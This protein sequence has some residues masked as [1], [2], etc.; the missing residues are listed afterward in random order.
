MNTYLDLIK[1]CNLDVVLEKDPTSKFLRGYVKQLLNDNAVPVCNTWQEWQSW[2]SSKPYKPTQTIEQTIEMSRL[3]PSRRWLNLCEYERV[4]FSKEYTIEVVGLV[5][6]IVGDTFDF[7]EM[8]ED[9]W[10]EVYSILA[11]MLECESVEE[12]EKT[13]VDRI[14]EQVIDVLKDYIED[15]L[16]Q[17]GWD[18]NAGDL[19]VTSSEII[20]ADFDFS[21]LIS[22]VN[23]FVKVLYEE[24]LNQL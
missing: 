3:D 16:Y 20:D 14:S 8:V 2:L 15:V 9:N 1:G 21:D 24:K 17:F 13:N 22:L 10:N 11:P 23:D 19:E 6:R 18:Y 5:T 7:K 4:Y 12:L